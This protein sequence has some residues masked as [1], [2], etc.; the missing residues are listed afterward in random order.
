MEKHLNKILSEIEEKDVEIK[1]LRNDFDQTTLLLNTDDDYD[2]HHNCSLCHDKGH[3]QNKCTGVK[4]PSSK[5]CWK[6]KLHKEEI[7][8]HESMKA[9]VKKLVKDKQ[10]LQ[11]EADKA[12]EAIV[13]NNKSFFQA[14]RSYLI[15]SDKLRYLTKYGRKLSP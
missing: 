1:K 15:N 13:M 11:S 10:T 8:A 14:V 3:R 4:C 2:S 12:Q 7:K 6:M 5:I 9:S